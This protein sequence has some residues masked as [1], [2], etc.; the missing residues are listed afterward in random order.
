MTTLRETQEH[1]YE[2][3]TLRNPPWA[4][5]ELILALDLYLRRGRL[6]A[7]DPDVVN[8]SQVLNDL[9]IHSE[10]PDE[11][12]F[13]NPN[14]VALKL[15]NFAAID[16]TYD[17]RGMVR[18]SK[19][20][21]MVWD[22]YSS[23]DDTRAAIA[24]AIRDGL[25]LPAAGPAEPTG[26]RIT[27]VEIEEQHVEHFQVSVPNQ[28]NEATRREQSLVLAYTD[29]LRNKGHRVTRHRYQP[30]GSSHTLVCDLFDKTDQV[31]YEAKGDVLRMS[32]RTA[33]GQLLDYRR[34]ESSPISLAIL[35]PREP[36]ED[37]VELIRSVPAAVVWRTKDGFA[38]IPPP[39]E[40]D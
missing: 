9:T 6:S 37:L 21:A 36:A 1:N 35:L 12:R 16:P 28:A 34:F 5:E 19:R 4:E 24:A 10:R 11:A 40:D 29:H 22:Q 38:S 32:V 23:D 26:P 14:G 31:L 13:R 3:G 20:D 33:I 27:E 2:R 7:A 30:R 18:G 25:G 17:N 39:S 15:A 8:L